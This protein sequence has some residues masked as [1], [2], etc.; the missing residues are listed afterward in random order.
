[1]AGELRL[2]IVLRSADA[3]RVLGMLEATASTL[4]LLFT[5]DGKRLVSGH[6]SGD[7]AFWDADVERWPQR[8][9]EIANR[10]LTREEWTSAVGDSPPYRAP[11]PSLPLPPR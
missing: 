9:C 3:Q 4:A 11:C 10:N 6:S 2:D 5:P 1:V 8:A 7:V